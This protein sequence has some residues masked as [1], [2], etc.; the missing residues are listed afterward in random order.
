MINY[1]NLIFSNNSILRILQIQECNNFKLNSDSLEL[2]LNHKLDRNFFKKSLKN[3]KT[4]YSNK[5][6]KNKNF[7][8]INLEK[9]IFHKKKYD[10][11]LCKV[12]IKIAK[13]TINL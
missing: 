1:F 8:V 9:K 5:E 10:I 4:F 11:V 6:K 13:K 2:G 3:R 7:P 12:D